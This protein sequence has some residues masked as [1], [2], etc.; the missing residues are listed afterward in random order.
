[1]KTVF[2]YSIDILPGRIQEIELK[3]GWKFLSSQIQDRSIC[4][5]AEVDPD[6]MPLTELFA[7]IGTGWEIPID[8]EHLAT[9]QNPPFVWHLYKKIPQPESKGE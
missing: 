7:L 6:E 1:V 8:S 4:I 5:W 3:K 9:I 2:K